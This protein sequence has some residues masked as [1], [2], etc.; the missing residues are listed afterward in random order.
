MRV[1]LKELRVHLGNYLE[2]GEEIE[3]ESRG[4]VIGAFT[5]TKRVT[6]EAKISKKETKVIPT[7]EPIKTP[8]KSDK[9]DRC[10]RCRMLGHVSQYLVCGVQMWRCPQCAGKD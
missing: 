6:A 10:S 8:P 5:P 4:K 2:R 9:P 1:G 3:V 7:I